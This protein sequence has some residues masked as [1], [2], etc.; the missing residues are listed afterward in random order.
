MFFCP[1]AKPLLISHFS[2]FPNVIYFKL[3]FHIDP[4]HISS[5]F[6]LL[7]HILEHIFL[8]LLRLRVGLK[9]NIPFLDQ[10]KGSVGTRGRVSWKMKRLGGIQPGLGLCFYTVG[11]MMSST[12]LGDSKEVVPE[13]REE[14]HRSGH[15]TVGFLYQMKG[16][17]PFP[18][19]KILLSS[20]NSKS[21]FIMY[22]LFINVL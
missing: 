6:S 16:N 5:L 10:Y 3:T 13:R 9:Q 17:V 14:I 19:H 22:L 8:V 1:G 2:H 20:K 7:F 15:L 4:A 18:F 12:Q 11:M 21:K